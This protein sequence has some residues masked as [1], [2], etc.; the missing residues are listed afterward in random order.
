[1]CTRI[2]IVLMGV[3]SVLSRS[4]WDKYNF[5]PDSS[6]EIMPFGWYSE[7]GASQL[8]T[9]EP[10][11]C[12]FPLH[13]NGQD[14][15]VVLDFKKNVA[16]FTT[17][18]FGATSDAA[19]V[20]GLAFSESSLYAACPSKAVGACADGQG[21]AGAGDHSNGGHGPDGTLET[22]IITANTTFTPEVRHMRG[23]FRYLNIF[24]K[25][26]GSVVINNVSVH[27]TA[28]PTMKNPRAYVCNALVVV[29]G[30]I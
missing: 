23:G 16:G 24:L 26:N 30:L 22:G 15:H 11:T 17:V 3:A 13:L 19:Q 28:A 14:S 10:T 1:M 7:T 25:T 12:C 20:V 21:Q 6:R 2:M 9:T 8:S 27:F 5:S 29:T 4:P 18:S